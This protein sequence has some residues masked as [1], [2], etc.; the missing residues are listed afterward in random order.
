MHSSDVAKLRALN[1]FLDGL[2]ELGVDKGLLKNKKLL[3]DLLE[4]EKEYRDNEDCEKNKE[5]STDSEEEEE[6]SL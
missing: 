4:K 3:S 2:A 5:Q 1:T 6:N